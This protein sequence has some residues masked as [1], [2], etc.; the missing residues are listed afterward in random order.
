MGIRSSSSAW[1]VVVG[2]VGALLLS[3]NALLE[4][5]SDLPVTLLGKQVGIGWYRQ[6]M[7]F[8][9]SWYRQK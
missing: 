2:V 5:S 7:N 6:G 8:P 4:L 1:F 9:V 3:R